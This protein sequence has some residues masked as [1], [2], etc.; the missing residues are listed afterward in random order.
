M[1]IRSGVARTVGIVAVA[2]LTFACAAAPQTRA[3]AS[4]DVKPGVIAAD[5]IEVTAT[6]AA[7]D[8]TRRL[9]AL[10]GPQ[11]NTIILRAGPEVRNLDQVKVGDRV[12]VDHYESIALFV[13]KSGDAP[14]ATEAAVVALAAKGQTPGVVSVDTVEV[15]AKVEAIDYA[16]RVVTLIGPEGTPRVIKVDPSVKRLPEVN[17]GDEVVLRYTEALAVAVRK[18]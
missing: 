12:I 15:T 4:T 9:V 16:K 2:A 5:L 13:R 18:P 7:I 17:T 11:G 3:E 6:V 1:R 8:P 10:T 14:A